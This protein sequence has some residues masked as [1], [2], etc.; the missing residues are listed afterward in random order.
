LVLPHIKPQTAALIAAMGVKPDSALADSSEMEAIAAFVAKYN[1]CNSHEQNLAKQVAMPQASNP[2]SRSLIE[3]RN[4]LASRL[5][6]S[7]G[8]SAT[9]AN[10]KANDMVTKYS[11]FLDYSEFPAI[12]AK[13]NPQDLFPNAHDS[14]LPFSLKV[15][16]KL[17]A[18][19]VAKQEAEEKGEIT[20]L[21]RKAAEQEASATSL[22]ETTLPS[23]SGRSQITAEI[24]NAIIMT[25]LLDSSQEQ[26]ENLLNPP[27]KLDQERYQADNP[28]TKT[29]E[30]S[31]EISG[32]EELRTDPE[33][34]NTEE[35]ERLARI[36]S[37][38][39]S[40]TPPVSVAPVVERAEKLSETT[41]AR[42]RSF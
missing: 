38:V 2:D 18:E 20:Q 8:L 36:M 35:K 4:I 3:I 39:I 10:I 30:I 7:P 9:K 6:E 13:N 12:F 5:R 32:N 24:Q 26:K 42:S 11:A 22:T 34:L 19:L 27:A 41:K 15:W 31:G 21:E 37:A 1:L 17:R 29:T 25:V 40:E 16:N 23:D 14:E 28:E 33:L